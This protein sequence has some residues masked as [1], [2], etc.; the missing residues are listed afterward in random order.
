MNSSI[1]SRIALLE[2]R[3]ESLSDA[4][5][6]FVEL[7]PISKSEVEE[8][9]SLAHPPQPVRE[10]LEIVY[11]TLHV[12]AASRA[13]RSTSHGGRAKFDWAAVR[14][15]LVRFET[16]FPAMHSYDITPLVSSPALANYLSRTYFGE[17]GLTL[18]RTQRCSAA[19]GALFRWSSGAVAR[20]QAALELVSVNAE[21]AGLRRQA[22]S[23]EEIVWR[24]GTDEGWE[25]Y[26]LELSTRISAARPGA[27]VQFD[28]GGEGLEVNITARTERNIASGRLRPVRPSWASETVER[29]DFLSSRALFRETVPLLALQGSWRRSTGSIVTVRETT[30]VLDGED[31][32]DNILASDGSSTRWLHNGVWLDSSGSPFRVLW[33]H[34]SFE[35]T[36]EPEALRDGAA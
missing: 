23:S 9:R 10:C 24:R 14:A 20:A 16:F 13:L 19:A 25:A 35:E 27:C 2:N 11:A 18:E 28:L 30:L 31:S 32:M 4:S 26:P 17:D 5:E 15:M 21:L 22:V 3:R 6:A 12:E 1:F 29:V 33:T 36:W 7:A 8:M 34:D